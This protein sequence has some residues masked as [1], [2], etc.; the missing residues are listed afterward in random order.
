M[1]VQD[2]KLVALIR[3]VIFKFELKK[4]LELPCNT[5]CYVDDIPIPHTW[6]TLES[7]SNEFCI[8]F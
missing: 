7:H 1:P 3:A 6:R 4:Q 8:T 2:L 5:V